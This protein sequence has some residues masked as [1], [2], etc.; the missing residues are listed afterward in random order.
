MSSQPPNMPPGG[1]VPPYDPRTQWRIYRE[2]Q[3]AAWRAQRDAWKAQRYAWRAHTPGLYGPRV[4]SVVGPIILIAVGIVGL[5]IY[6][7][8]VSWASA[9]MWYGKWW[10]LL[11]IAAGLA[12]LAEWA[13]DLKRD[14]PVRRSNGFIG[15]LVLLAFLGFAASGWAGFWGPFR[16]HWGN[17]GDD[18]FN[19]F[20]LP[21]HDFD[22]E[23]LNVQIPANATVQI[24]NPRG[25]V[26]VT[27]GDVTN[28]TVQAHEVAYAGSDDEAKK[29]FDAE[30]AHVNVSGTAVLVRSAGNSNGR[31]NLTVTVPKSAS[32]SINAGRG[33]I[34]AAG[35]NNGVNITSSRGEVHVNS[36]EG[37]VVAHFTDGRHDFS[38]HQVNGDVAISGNS[39]DL[40]LSEIKGKVS[41]DGEIFGDVHLETIAGLVHMH[42][43]VTSLD[44]ASLPGDMTLNSDDLRIT[45]AKGDVRVVT[46]SKDVDLNDIYGNSSVEDR[47]GRVAVSP[48][49]NF[50]VEV[51]NEKG[52][53]EVTLPPNVQATVSG[54][55][56]NGDIISDFPITITGDEDKSVNG[57]IGAGTAKISLNTD[58]GDLHIK[59]ASSEPAAPP[60]PPAPPVKGALHL[61]APKALPESPVTQ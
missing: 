44:I 42:T 19:V 45:Q 5:L 32:V 24:E 59:R 30:Q 18:F 58:N 54:S 14:T 13:I 7:G 27:A 1:G 52:D 37:S 40:T 46:R 38:A 21:E 55:T 31:V 51:K 4:P 34:T 12:M 25:D 11:L 10:P 47:N 39:N 8:R 35:L 9:A 20:G 29:I 28:I 2:Q 23:V 48:A 49:G 17:N 3:R 60:A 53:V 41:V 36:I 61:H 16:G 6:T 50:N 56:R 33:D 15:V 43:S 26:N 57:R 22:Q